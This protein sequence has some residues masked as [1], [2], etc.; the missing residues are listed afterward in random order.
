MKTLLLG[1][2]YLK[3]HSRYEIKTA[4][5]S[6]GKVAAQCSTLRYRS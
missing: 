6:G 3:C 1:N 5:F 4:L 2:Q